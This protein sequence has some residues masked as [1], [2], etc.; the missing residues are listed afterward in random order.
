MWKNVLERDRQQVAMWRMRFARWIP[1]A[2]YT[3]SEYVILI[4]FP[5]EQW[6][7]ERPSM[8][9]YT[10]VACLVVTQYSDTSANEDNSFRNHIR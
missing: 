3:H 10:Y 2:K 8:L 9:R 1:K 6:L 7:L 4:T 5:L